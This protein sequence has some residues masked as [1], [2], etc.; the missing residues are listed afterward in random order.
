MAKTIKQLEAELAKVSED[1][2]R[3]YNVLHGTEAKFDPGL[4]R[5]Y[6]AARNTLKKKGLFE[7]A[8]VEAEQTIT[9]LEPRIKAAEEEYKKFQEQK[10]A[11][12]KELKAAKA[13]EQKTK[14]TAVNIKSANKVYENAL[15]NL[16][17]A[18]LSLSGYK[19][20]EKYVTAYQK[21]QEAFN[22]VTQLGAT[23]KKPLPEAKT[24]IPPIVQTGGTSTSTGTQDT[25][26]EGIQ[27]YSDALRLLTDPKFKESL[28]NAQK[29]LVKFGYKGNTKGEPDLSFATALRKASDE[30]LTLPPAWRPASLLDYIANPLTGG[31]GGAGAGTGAGG[32]ANIQTRISDPTQAASIIQPVVKKLLEREAS[33]EEV[34]ALTKILNDAEKKNPYKTVGG[35]TTG[36]LDRTQFLVDLITSGSYKGASKASAA[37][38]GTLAKEVTEAKATAEA[39]KVGLEE[40]TATVNRNSILKTAQAN[41]IPLSED[42]VNTYLSQL[43]EGQNINTVLQN[44]RESASL[45]MPEKVAKLLSSGTDLDTVYA[46]YK[47]ILAKTLEINPSSITLDDPTLRMAIGPDKEMSLY[48]YQRA[49]RKDNRWQYTDQAKQEASDVARTVLRDFGFMW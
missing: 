20:E 47:T 5:Q 11:L 33:A 15:S 30:Y 6:E 22:A 39:K 19:G 43:K 45:G 3:A 12:N 35:T 31:A 7:S 17:K 4:L 10:N 13:E 36:G 32:A 25:G 18:E 26:V 1:T 8:R 27:S 16:D 40:G 41:G 34:A 46:P 37:I 24:V 29:E 44:I 28:I 9:S 23:P 38:L 49:L 48:E 21:A 14:V 2:R 42:Q